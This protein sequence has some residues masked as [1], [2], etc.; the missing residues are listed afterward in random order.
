MIFFFVLNLTFLLS[1]S[2]FCQKTA[3]AVPI[4]AFISSSHL[5]SSLIQLPKYLYLSICS[6][7]LLSKTIEHI[8]FPVLLTTIT[9]VFFT[10]IAIPYTLQDSFSLSIILCK[11]F[12][13]SATNTASSVYLKFVLL[14]PLKR[15]P[16]SLSNAS[17][18]MYSLYRLKS[19][20]DMMQPCL[21][22][23][24]MLTYLLISLSNLTAAC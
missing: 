1:N 4:L 5:A 10:F 13:V 8:S 19:I 22:P 16:F 7:I 14:F 11:A 6:N 18:I 15:T 12:R 24:L 9:L 17:V 21:T 20:G 3:L 2:L 23:L